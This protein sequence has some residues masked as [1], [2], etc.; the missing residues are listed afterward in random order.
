MDWNLKTTLDGLYA[1]GTQMFAPE[2]HSYA[3]A[4]GRYA[5]RKAAAYAREIGESKISRDQIET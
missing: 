4:T 3:A 1:A 5:G 2:D